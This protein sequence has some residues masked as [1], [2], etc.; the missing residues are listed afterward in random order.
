M[1]VRFLSGIFP[2]RTLR[3]WKLSVGSVN[4]ST[5][6]LAPIS[7]AFTFIRTVNNFLETA[8]V[9]GSPDGVG[10]A[11]GERQAHHSGSLSHRVAF[12]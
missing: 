11:R 12:P 5:V 1:P 4:L 8:T 7:S 10:T 3:I 9:P 6:S 2:G